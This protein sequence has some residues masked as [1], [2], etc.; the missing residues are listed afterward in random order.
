MTEAPSTT[1][2]SRL[3]AAIAGRPVTHPVY[4]VYDGFV[5]TRPHVDWPRLFAL[6][7]GQISHADVLRHEHPNLQIVETTRQVNGQTR[8]DVRWITDRGE[9]HQWYLGDWRQEHFIKTPE[10]YR[11]MRR[12][13]EG[14]KITAD[15]TAFLAAERQVGDNGVTLGNIAGMGLGRTPLMV[16]QVDWVGLER[17]SVD[18]A[19]ELPPMMELLEFMNELKL[20]E[21]RQAVRTPARQIKLWENLSIQTLGPDRYRRHLVPLYS[22]I[23]SILQAAGKQLQVHYDGQLRVIADQVAQLDFDGI[24]SLTPP[25]EGDLTVAEARRLWPDRM[26]WCHPSLDWF[27]DGGKGL[28]PLIRGLVKDAGPRRFCLMISEEIPPDWAQTVPQVL[29]LLQEGLRSG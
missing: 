29:S 16:L 5:T 9:L 26:L 10:D 4:A 7:L 25:P 27:R 3:E 19:D 13:W 20:E 23:L 1:N 21:F 24:D 15:D 22:K 28:G 17:W 2:R 14:V 8:R 11:I 18:L 6:G 12:A